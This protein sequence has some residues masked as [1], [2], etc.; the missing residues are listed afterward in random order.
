MGIQVFKHGFYTVYRQ[1]R[2]DTIVRIDQAHQA[3]EV[4]GNIARC[5]VLRTPEAKP[6]HVIR[7]HAV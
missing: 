4:P 1:I 6:I 5:V 2:E 3:N 7:R